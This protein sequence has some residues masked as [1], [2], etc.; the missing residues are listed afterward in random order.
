MAIEVD[1]KLERPTEC[2]DGMAQVTL[3]N[4][5]RRFIFQQYIKMGYTPHG[6]RVGAHRDAHDTMVRAGFPKFKNDDWPP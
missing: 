3:Y 2:Y 1:L 4:R 5:V 6:A